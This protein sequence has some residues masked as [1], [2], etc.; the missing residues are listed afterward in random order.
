M[1]LPKSLAA[2]SSSSGRRLAGHERVAQAK[3]RRGRTGLAEPPL[4]EADLHRVG[5][6]HPRPGGRAEVALLAGVGARERRRAGSEPPSSLG[7]TSS[8]R[9]RDTSV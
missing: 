4:D 7:R 8:A 5:R 1:P 3:P 9:A 2:A 6:E